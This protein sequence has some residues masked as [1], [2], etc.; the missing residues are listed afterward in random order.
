MA[1][2][3]H[4]ILFT[5]NAVTEKMLLKAEIFRICAHYVEPQMIEDLEKLMRKGKNFFLLGAGRS[6]LSG[7][8]FAMRF[9]QMDIRG[10]DVYVVGETTTIAPKK[11][12]VVI[13]VS[14]SGET[15]KIKNLAIQFK[16]RGAKLALLGANKKS[17]IGDIADVFVYIPKKSQIL[18][19][20]PDFA[21]QVA[22]FKNWAP[23]GT[24]SEIFALIFLDTI[25][26]EIMTAYDKTDKDLEAMHQ[27]E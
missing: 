15:P 7:R 24:I 26:S 3:Q 12:D 17:S 25:A 1:R 13:A 8:A 4:P 16:A 9:A 21:T 5:A 20:H 6:D 18:A 14:S 23:L 10:V 19:D 2:K 11:G 27:I 22:Q